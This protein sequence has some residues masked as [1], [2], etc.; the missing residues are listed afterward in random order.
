MRDQARLML[1]LLL[2]LLLPLQAAMFS[3]GDLGDLCALP[4]VEAENA[5][6]AAALD[7]ATRAFRTFAPLDSCGACVRAGGAWCLG[8]PRKGARCVPDGRGMCGMES[9][10]TQQGGRGSERGG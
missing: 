10:P 3:A 1:L 6:A 2:L 8:E 7:A 5:V 9:A 4:N